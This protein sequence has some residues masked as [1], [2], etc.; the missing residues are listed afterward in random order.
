MVPL[1]YYL[2]ELSFPDSEHFS[3]TLRAGATCG[4]S[5]VLQGDLLG[6]LYLDFTSAL[7]TIG[8]WH[9]FASFF[10]KFVLKLS[11][12]YSFVNS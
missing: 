5:L 7:H 1:S 11:H 12:S 3:T 9:S 4:R 6:I 2:L 10:M 8:L